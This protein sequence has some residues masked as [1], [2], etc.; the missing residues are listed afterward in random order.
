[1]PP[2]RWETAIPTP[3]EARRAFLYRATFVAAGVYNIAFGL[4]AALSPA[5]FFSALD[6]DPPT[7]YA[8]WSALGMVVG[9]YGLAYFY[10][11]RR[12][13]RAWP[14]IAIG[15]L[16]KIIGPIG[17][18]LAVLDGALPAQTFILIAFNDILWWLPFSL[19]LLEES[20]LGDHIRALAPTACAV[21]NAVAALAL[22][23]VLRQGTEAEPDAA[24]RATYVAGHLLEWRVGWA[25][26]IAAGT[27]LVAFY[28]WW[29][30]RLQ[31]WPLG[32][33][34]VALATLG[35]LF[36]RLGL[37]LLIGWAPE[38]LAGAMPLV[39]LA[40]AVMA[41]GL[42]VAG[43]ALL[44]LLTPSLPLHLRAWAWALW[45]TGAIL[46]IASLV[47]WTEGV[48]AGT[49]VLF[50]FLPPWCLLVGRKIR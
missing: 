38:G 8:F 23:L 17:W 30:A 12:L 1:L 46:S 28:A 19:F 40:S 45:V 31:E 22:L 11:A 37:S 34:A 26:W 20:R 41:N 32:L 36:D 25:L 18:L 7:Y 24:A 6:M 14:F 48:V 3:I 29:A 42:Y 9:V 15:L 39:T 21:T 27:S 44:T 16:G 50:T 35:L 5:D 2:R 49:A 10:A 43:G 4:W 33:A 47:G 13:D